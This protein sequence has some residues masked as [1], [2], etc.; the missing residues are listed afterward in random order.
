MAH[1][2]RVGALGAVASGLPI[3][4]GHMARGRTG[5][6][7]VRKGATVRRRPRLLHAPET[8]YRGSSFPPLGAVRHCA[9]DDR[10]S[11]LTRVT[12]AG[13]DARRSS[14]FVPVAVSPVGSSRYSIT[15]SYSS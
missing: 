11:R 9:Q 1:S 2:V 6:R 12:N 14:F 5:R 13:G 15:L 4:G 3:A 10:H 7:G 8:P